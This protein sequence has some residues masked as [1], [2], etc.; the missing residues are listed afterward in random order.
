MEN[1]NTYK[2]LRPT[3]G[4]IAGDIVHLTPEEAENW[5]AGE[6][7]PRIEE[8]REGTEPEPKPEMTG[9]TPEG[10]FVDDE[11]KT[12]ADEQTEQEKMTSETAEQSAENE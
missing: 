6:T 4:Y 8:V 7:N 10:E 11:P 3:N 2:V 1:R 5:N 9:L 12:S